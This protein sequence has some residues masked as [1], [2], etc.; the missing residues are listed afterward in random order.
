MTQ[1]YLSILSYL[2]GSILF[3][4]VIAK[5]K[6]IENLRTSGSGNVGATNIARVSGNKKL[7]IVVAILDALKGAIPV[8]VAGH[9]SLTDSEIA[10]V[11]IMA[12][13]GH[14]FPIWHSFKGGKGVATFLG[15]NLLLDW[16]VGVFMAMTWLITFKVTKVSS[17]SSIAMVI[18]SIVASYLLNLDN[19]WQV[20]LSALLVILKHKGNINRIIS[21]KESKIF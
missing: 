13:I 20:S 3:G 17:I 9:F 4:I 8:I 18:A 21:G 16:R 1:L 10:T 2:L 7:G 15:M 14:I 6:G 19:L 12:V 11:G 5:I